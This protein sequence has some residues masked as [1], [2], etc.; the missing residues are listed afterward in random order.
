MIH[1]GGSPRN[2]GSLNPGNNLYVTMLSN[3]TRE[4]SLE[5]VF[6]RYGRVQLSTTSFSAS[7]YLIYQW[8]PLG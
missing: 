6:A 1:F 5:E 4:S 7:R 2:D 3:R 8:R